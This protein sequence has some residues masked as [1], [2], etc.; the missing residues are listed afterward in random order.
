[1]WRCP[2]QLCRVAVCCFWNAALLGVLPQL[3]PLHLRPTCALWY[4]P[5]CC[6]ALTALLPPLAAF[7]TAHA[8]LVSGLELS[9]QQVLLSTASQASVLL[10]LLLQCLDDGRLVLQEA[11]VLR[12]LAA[13]AVPLQLQP[14]LLL[15]AAPHWQEVLPA[16]GYMQLRQMDVCCRA[17]H[18]L[19][20]V[21]LREGHGLPPRVTAAAQATS[22]RPAV[23]LQWLLG[24]SE[25]A[26]AMGESCSA[27]LLLPASGG[28]SN[29]ACKAGRLSTAGCAP[30]GMPGCCSRLAPQCMHVSNRQHSASFTA[31]L[32]FPLLRR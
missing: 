7:G 5:L 17:V 12:L 2:L 28:K 32:P 8:A 4:C 18:T 6:S 15:W 3:L 25:A 11:D 29:T 22:L 30:K 16:G 19:I 24:I 27:V 1:M 31:S 20:F 10:I 23:L 9:R 14:K 26:S 13:A 21:A